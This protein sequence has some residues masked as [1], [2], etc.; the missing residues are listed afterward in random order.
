MGLFIADS[1]PRSR[2]VWIAAAG[3][4]GALAGSLVVCAPAETIGPSMQ[5]TTRCAQA[6]RRPAAIQADFAVDQVTVATTED[7]L[8]FTCRIT[9]HPAQVTG[10]ARVT[11]ARHA[12]EAELAMARNACI[13][14][15]VEAAN[16]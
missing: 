9:L 13:T 14:A 3:I 15:A 16:P 10:S 7:Q 1:I 8:T 6:M 4:A 12:S 11:A 2:L 5:R